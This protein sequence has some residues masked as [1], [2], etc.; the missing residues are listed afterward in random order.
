MN[1]PSSSRKKSLTGGWEEKR[2]D[3]GIQG[4]QIKDR[5]CHCLEIGQRHQTTGPPTTVEKRHSRLLRETRPK[6]KRRGERP[7]KLLDVSSKCQKRLPGHKMG[8][9]GAGMEGKEG[10]ERT[11]G[12]YYNR[13]LG[14]KGLVGKHYRRQ[15]G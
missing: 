4:N 15:P 10:R 3:Q 8:S 13:G 1:Q 9:Q 11:G 6:K 5:I 14:E 7:K 2:T 12:F